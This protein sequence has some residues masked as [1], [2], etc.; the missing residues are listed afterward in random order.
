MRKGGTSFLLEKTTNNKLD[1]HTKK[2]K[3]NNQMAP[4]TILKHQQDMNEAPIHRIP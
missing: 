3:T 4:V 2:V 1:G